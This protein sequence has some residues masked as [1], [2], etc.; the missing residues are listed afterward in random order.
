MLGG[1]VSA[2]FVASLCRVTV[3][4]T[5]IVAL[6]ACIWLIYTA[7]HLWD[8]YRL[9]QPAHTVR[10]RFH[11]N[12]FRSM[13]VIF[14]L[15]A[16]LGLAILFY[17]PWSVIR[18][19]L[20][21]SGGVALYF[22]VFQLAQLHQFIPK[23][24]SAALLYSLG[25]FLPVFAQVEYW[26]LHHT[27]FFGQ[28]FFLALANLTI[29]SYYEYDSDRLDKT[30]S[31]ATQYSVS[32]AQRVAKL[33]LLSAMI[34]LGVVLLFFSPQSSD[35]FA[36]LIFMLMIG[37]LAMVLFFSDLSRHK[38]SYRWIADGVFLLPIIY[39]LFA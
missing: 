10:H 1:C 26:Q 21:L 12:H 35:Y 16:L 19:G 27:L 31:L 15:I 39:L 13:L 36:Q 17:L 28:Y 7:D 3:E 22:L 38:E 37:V 34:L 2:W 18:S 33:S 5:T 4:P 30:S 11:Q 29:F 23:E 14:C 20:F 6:G 24:L 32:V 8:A 9:N 25:I